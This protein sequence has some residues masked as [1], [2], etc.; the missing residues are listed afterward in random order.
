MAVAARAAADRAL[1]AAAAHRDAERDVAVADARRAADGAA[2]IVAGL[3]PAS[4]SAAEPLGFA[5]TADAEAARAEGS[6]AREQAWATAR[7]PLGGARPAVPR[8]LC[9][10]PRGRGDARGG[11]PAPR[12]LRRLAEARE[13]AESLGAAPLRDSIDG[14]ARRARLTLRAA[15]ADGPASDAAANAVEPDTVRGRSVRAD[16]PRARGPHPRRSRPDEQADRETLFI[17]EST[18]GVHVSNILGKLGVASRARRRP[19][20]PCG[21]A[22]PSELRPRRSLRR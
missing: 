4:P 18:A 11:H 7:R 1:A 12:R 21:S 6:A 13:I 9:A 20:S 17:S 10:V 19:P 22:W 16:G 5:A 3:D 2:T 15:R 14:V 8:R